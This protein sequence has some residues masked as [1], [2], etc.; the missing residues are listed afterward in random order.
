MEAE[1]SPDPQSASWRPREELM[2]QFESEGRKRLL[3][4]LNAVK[5]RVLGFCCSLRLFN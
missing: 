5:G 2:L 4:Q 1:K 3:S